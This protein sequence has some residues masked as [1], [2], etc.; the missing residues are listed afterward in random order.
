[1]NY[2]NDNDSFSVKWLKA[3]IAEGL[4]PKGDVDGRSITEIK[5]SELD[6]YTQ[7][8]FFTGI[9][10]WPY[11]LRLSGWPEDRPVFTGSC[12]CQPFSVAGQGKGIE[13]ERHLWPAFRWLIAQKRPATI[14]GEQVA[15]SDGREW[16]SGV[17][18]DLETMG[19]EVGAADMCAAGVGAPHIR[20]RLFWVADSKHAQ[21][22]PSNTA[23][24]QHNRKNTGREKKAGRPTAC[25]TIDHGMAHSKQQGLEGRLRGR[26]GKEWENIN[27]HAGRCGTT[28][29]LGITN[30]A[31]P[32]QGS[33]TAKG[34]R[35][36]DS[37]KPADFWSNSIPIP[38]A[39][40]KWRRVPTQPFLFPLAP[41]LPNRVGALRGA[42]NA[43]VPQVAAAFIKATG[44]LSHG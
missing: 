21:R 40:G 38:C 12:P 32:Q 20:Q 19:Y 13:D 36:R 44:M 5:P 29:G 35:H 4:I 6:G 41:R 11:A 10:G 27:G 33:K 42:G 34:T 1:V 8:H 15:S 22:R 14:F 39:D 37:S 26:Q 30:S 18:L 9:G 16:L 3:L 28:N 23:G 43:I 31:R 25:G 24:N 7:C 2:Y 17:R